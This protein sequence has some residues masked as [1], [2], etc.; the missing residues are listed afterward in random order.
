MKVLDLFCGAGGFSLGFRD[1]GFSVVGADIN[2]HSAKIYSTNNI[3]EFIE[4]DLS[5][6]S[7]DGMFEVVIGGLPCRPWSSINLQRRGSHHPDY[8]LIERFFDHI[9]RLRPRAFLMENVPPLMSDKVFGELKGKAIKKGYSVE[10]QSLKYLDFGVAT[11]RRR[12]F[13]VGFR[14]F[15]MDARDF[16]A[17]LE[18]VKEAP[19][20]VGKA[21]K[22]YEGYA[23]GDIPDHEWSHLNTI[24]KYRDYYES[25]KFGWSKLEY[26]GYAPSFGN[27][28]KTYILHPKA[29]EGDFPLRVLSVR[30]T[31]AI[32]G[33]PEDYRFPPEM[34][35]G[36][37]YQ[38][39]A[40]AVSPVAAQKMARVV[41]KI[42]ESQNYPRN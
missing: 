36:M 42:L 15:G 17:C 3:G 35:L 5:R 30:E 34:G 25:G 9:F 22:K 19:I 18:Q 23:E 6:D 8:N 29:G 31:L 33:F 4:I 1:A 20:T 7:V 12:L 2:Q 38:M 37:R 11:K 27:L 24:H 40:N 28:M 10:S 39:V 32:M 16:F 21:I 14:E 13:T 41:L 26:E